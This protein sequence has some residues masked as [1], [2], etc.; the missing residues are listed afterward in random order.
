VTGDLNNGHR[1]WPEP[2]YDL[3]YPPY[4]IWHGTKSALS[5]SGYRCLATVAPIGVKFCMIIHV[6]H[7]CLLPLWG[8]YP[9]AALNGGNGNLRQFWPESHFEDEYLENGNSER[10]MSIRA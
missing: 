1:S 3:Y 8:R 7:V 2:A 9:E 10:Y 6:S 4:V 5:L